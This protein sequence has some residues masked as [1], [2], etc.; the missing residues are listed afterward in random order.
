VQT[1]DDFSVEYNGKMYYDDVWLY[2]DNVDELDSIVVYGPFGTEFT[3]DTKCSEFFTGI[4]SIKKNPSESY[5]S[6]G[7]NR[8]VAWGIVEKAVDKIETPAIL[9]EDQQD[10]IRNAWLDMVAS[11]SNIDNIIIRILSRWWR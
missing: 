6:T 4:A 5:N 7:G 2:L 9:S 11:L 3:H 1:D 10:A 8:G